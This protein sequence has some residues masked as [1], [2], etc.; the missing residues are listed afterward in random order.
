MLI[1]EGLSYDDVLLV[2]QYSKLAKRADADISGELG[3]G[4]A[5]EVPII[6]ANMPSVASPK[7]IKAMRATGAIGAHHRFC[8]IIE[9]IHN[10]EEAGGGLI[11]LGLK[12]GMERAYRLAEA[13]AVTFIIDVAHGDHEQVVD[14]IK[15]FR[16]EPAFNRLYLIAGNVA[17]LTGAGRLAEQGIDAI[18]VGIGPGAACTTR[19]TTG[20]GVPQLSA[21]MEVAE[22]KRFYPQ[23]RV[24]ADGGIKNSG[25]IVKALAA[26]ADTVMIGS[27]FAGADE[28]PEPGVYYGSAS[29]RVNGHHAPEGVEGKV[30][31]AG[32]VS[33][34]IKR[35]AWGIRSGFSY[36]GATNIHELREN[37][38]WV[39][40]TP[41][42]MIESGTRIG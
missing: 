13:G 28:A 17:T 16:K 42:A 14:F 26:G 10:Y 41:Q 2:P 40:C 29:K 33:G 39:R 18:K 36:A 25:D 19:E 37:A 38:E 32:S 30:E 22:I 12:D 4:W 23:V 24:I 27:L 20:F 21:V 6:S 3:E 34:I 1:K 31:R 8:T 35:L 9:N 7:L 15:A 5:L 11:S